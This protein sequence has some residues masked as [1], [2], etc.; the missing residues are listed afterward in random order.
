MFNPNHCWYSLNIDTT[1][2]VNPSFQWPTPQSPSYGIWRIINVDELLN[3]SFLK[4]FEALGLNITVIMLFWKKAHMRN[5]E[6]HVDVERRNLSKPAVAGLNIVLKGRNSEMVWYKRPEGDLNIQWTHAKTP[7][8][9]WPV[10]Q[11]QEIDRK[12]LGTEV[13]L[14]RV[15]VPHAI[16]C[17]DEDRWCLSARIERQYEDWN[18]TVEVFNQKKI[19]ISR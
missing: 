9:G 8:V 6:A 7:Y 12:H 19:L 5:L 17:G 2:A 3:K 10:K 18:K 13:N 11:L 4:Q 1:D 14:V 15:D 16:V